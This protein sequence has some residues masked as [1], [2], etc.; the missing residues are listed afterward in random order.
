MPGVVI[1]STFLINAEDPVRRRHRHRVAAI[2]GGAQHSP[3]PPKEGRAAIRRDEGTD[4]D[5][6]YQRLGMH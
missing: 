6:F 4:Y 1:I 2:Y 3:P 5:A